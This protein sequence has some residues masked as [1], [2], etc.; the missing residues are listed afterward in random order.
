M[1]K[2]KNSLGLEVDALAMRLDNS[3]VHTMCAYSLALGARG[4]PK[5]SV[6]EARS[7]EVEK[8]VLL[9]LAVKVAAAPARARLARTVAGFAMADIVMWLWVAMGNDVVV[10]CVEAKVVG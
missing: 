1:E 7:E 2:W 9:L 4:F 10:V 3:T 5:A 8:S 6:S